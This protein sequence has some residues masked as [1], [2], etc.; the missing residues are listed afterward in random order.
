MCWYLITPL[1]WGSVSIVGQAIH[2]HHD[3]KTR[4]NCCLS[5]AVYTA[6]YIQ[7]RRTSTNSK[8]IRQRF[9]TIS[10]I[11]RTKMDSAAGAKLNRS[12]YINS[13]EVACYYGVR[14]T[15]NLA[16]DRFSVS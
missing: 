3:S 5:E 6:V 9:M 12:K 8:I 1:I 14:T 16:S 4:R 13:Q 7:Y 11:W 2:R 10:E 15:T